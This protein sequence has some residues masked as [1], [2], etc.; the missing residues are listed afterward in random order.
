MPPTD[1]CSARC[2]RECDCASRLTPLRIARTT[3]N[4]AARV[5][6]REAMQSQHSARAIRVCNAL[7]AALHASFR[8]ARP[9]RAENRC[10]LPQKLVILHDHYL[11]FGRMA[12]S[13]SDGEATL[14]LR[15]ERLASVRVVASPLSMCIRF[16]E[17]ALLL[18]CLRPPP[19]PAA[20]AGCN[21]SRGTVAPS[22]ARMRAATRAAGRPVAVNAREDL[23]ANN[24][25]R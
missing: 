24:E 1:G 12:M 23:Q 18:S 15:S 5:G 11:L 17:R 22:S 8:R 6:P 9:S 7:P 14:R 25:S 21:C 4:D 10:V 3:V 13:L 16:A 19:P 2:G 20:D